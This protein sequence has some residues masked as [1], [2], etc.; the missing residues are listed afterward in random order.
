MLNG[1]RTLLS[2]V[3]RFLFDLWQVTSQACWPTG[4]CS[5]FKVLSYYEPLGHSFSHL[6]N[7]AQPWQQLVRYFC[8]L[9]DP[10]AAIVP[11]SICGRTTCLPPPFAIH[12]VSRLVPSLILQW[13]RIIVPPVAGF[14]Y[15][16]DAK[17][18]AVAAITSSITKNYGSANLQMHCLPV[19]LCV[20]M[21]VCAIY[22]K[23]LGSK[24][25]MLVFIIFRWVWD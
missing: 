23:H 11:K 21:C 19:A 16:H 25:L 4:C 1:S 2:W 5:L 18:Q 7:L 3:Q 9:W 24:L 12:H 14:N 13:L 10:N 6:L 15:S 20:A 22:D 8:S 17:A